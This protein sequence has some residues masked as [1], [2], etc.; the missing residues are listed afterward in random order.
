[1]L[2]INNPAKIFLLILFQIVV[3]ITSEE[4]DTKTN[5]SITNN[6]IPEGFVRIGQ[7]NKSNDD[8]GIKKSSIELNTSYLNSNNSN[9]NGKLLINQTS[10]DKAPKIGLQ[11]LVSNSGSTNN[12][13]TLTPTSLDDSKSI[14]HESISNVSSSSISVTLLIL[15]S[16]VVVSCIIAIILTAL[17][18]MRRRFSIWRLNGARANGSSNCNDGANGVLT[19]GSESSENGSQFD[20]KC[21]TTEVN[22]KE[23]QCE[24]DNKEKYSNESLQSETLANDN[25]VSASCLNS[26][27]NKQAIMSINDQLEDAVK[28][29]DDDNKKD[30]K[31]EEKKDEIKQENV[32]PS[33]PSSVSPLIETTSE[34]EIKTIT[35]NDKCKEEDKSNSENLKQETSSSSL[36]VNVLNELSESVASKLAS[37]AKSPS[38]SALNSNDPEKQPLNDE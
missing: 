15:I 2:A 9:F 29:C 28:K 16:L 11:R 8:T 21:I 38:K 22:E 30:K 3:L 7:A 34:K 6:T 24:M 27:E 32:E 31:E 19:N 1:M 23:K 36:I 5:S 26:V 13:N 37:T 12:Q 35:T 14:T 33:S 10:S 20:N 4:V 18:V 17:F 25:K